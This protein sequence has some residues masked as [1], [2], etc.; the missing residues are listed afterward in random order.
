M[1]RLVTNIAL[2]FAVLLGGALFGGPE[3]L[4]LG[5]EVGSQVHSSVDWADPESVALARY[6][7]ALAATLEP[8]ALLYEAANGGD[9]APHTEEIHRALDEA[10]ALAAE[11]AVDAP[12]YL[13]HLDPLFIA[14]VDR[15][16]ALVEAWVP[17]QPPR[18][19]LAA[20]FDAQHALND[21]LDSAQDAR[22]LRDLRAHEDDRG[23]AYHHRLVHYHG[24][25]LVRRTIDSMVDPGVLLTA[26]E[27][28]R[29]AEER[30]LRFVDERARVHGDFALFV[31]ATEEFTR[32]V[33][34]LDPDA[35]IDA[36][37]AIRAQ[38]QHLLRLERA[39]E[40]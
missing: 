11:A 15:A 31:Q 35:L 5:D 14:Y 38:R 29:G 25:R 34:D 4:S 20:T 17:E 37:G 7:T 9:P 33:D 8:L 30:L 10:A 28:Y 22:L 39:G 18:A 16:G 24:F 21:A 26:I 36:F 3:I 1:A 27:G 12:A 23:Y 19:L 2:F 13:A 6:Q 32:A 40:I